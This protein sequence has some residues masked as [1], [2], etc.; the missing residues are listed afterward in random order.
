MDA[1]ERI[2]A[3]ILAGAETA[4]GW[5]PCWHRDG[6]TMPVNA[7]SGRR[8]EGINVL[9]CWVAQQVNGF[10]SMKWATYTQWQELGAQVSRGSKGTP[11][12]FWSRRKPKEDEE[13]GAW[14][15]RS[16]T[17]FN[18]DQ[19]VDPPDR[20]EGLSQDARVD[21]LE[22]FFGEVKKEAR[23]EERDQDMAYYDRGSD[24]VV[25][26]TFGRFR[27]A[28]SYYSVLLHELTHWTGHPDREARTFGQRFGDDAY[29]LEELT[30][31]LGA[32]FVA[33]DLGLRPEARSDHA[34]YIGHWFRIL[35]EQPAAFGHAVGQARKA[36]LRINRIVKGDSDDERTEEH[37]EPAILA[38]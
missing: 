33:A 37:G 18:Q 36:A 12:V 26:P 25:I 29:A 30:A 20:F 38:G 27:D 4:E 35:K 31:E 24:T 15:A 3:A 16:Y 10:G 17:V 9:S 1:Y 22:L 32:A 13:E 6:L 19:V 11:I 2:A 7:L 21:T 34:Q 14:F 23:I 5:T 8:Y 28:E